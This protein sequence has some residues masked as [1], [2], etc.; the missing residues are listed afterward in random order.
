MA[1]RGLCAGS[2]KR[3]PEQR[4]FYTLTSTYTQRVSLLKASNLGQELTCAQCLQQLVDH[5]SLQFLAWSSGAPEIPATGSTNV[6]QSINYVA[7]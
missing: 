3:F 1:L 5:V 7:V 6:T 4:A 2:W